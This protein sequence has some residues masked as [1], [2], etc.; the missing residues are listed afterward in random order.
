MGAEQAGQ[1]RGTH[2]TDVENKVAALGQP[3]RLDPRGQVPPGQRPRPSSGSQ[4]PGVE[5][6]RLLE[7]G[8]AEPQ[9][10]ERIARDVESEWEQLRRAAPEFGGIILQRWI[11]HIV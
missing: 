2:V 7:V 10:R 6:A 5:K 9:A 4:D 3:R 8:P 11:I 1:Q